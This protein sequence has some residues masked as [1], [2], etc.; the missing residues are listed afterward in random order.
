MNNNLNGNSRA[1]NTE[2]LTLTELQEAI[3]FLKSEED[4]ETLWSLLS[5]SPAIEAAHIIGALSDAGWKPDEDSAAFDG[6]VR[7]AIPCRTKTPPFKKRLQV[8]L[9]LF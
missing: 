6:L 2:T 7:L 9:Y 8:P 5:I 4:W 3:A 1:L